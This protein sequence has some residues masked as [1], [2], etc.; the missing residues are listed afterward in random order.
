MSNYAFKFS[1]VILTYNNYAE[2]TGPCLRSVLSNI[3]P[4]TTEIII[5]D[6]C[7]KDCTVDE[8]DRYIESLDEKF[9]IKF[10][11]N[12]SNLGYAAGNNVGIKISSGEFIVLLNNDTL[13]S[14]RWLEGMHSCFEHDSTLGL[15][16]PI[17]NSVGNEQLVHFP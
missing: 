16:G 2:V 9:S 6:N 4:K 8:L 13:V 17:T 15:V 3:D 14:P 11:K 10:Q 1:V 5:V 7:S 12:K